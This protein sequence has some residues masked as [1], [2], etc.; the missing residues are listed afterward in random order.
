[1]FVGGRFER[2]HA[3]CSDGDEAPAAASRIVDRLR[4]FGADGEPFS[5]HFVTFDLLHAHGFERPVPDVKRNFDDVRAAR[6]Y[7]FQNARREMES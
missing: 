4:R 1:V 5:G 7:F 2:A 6:P 3:G